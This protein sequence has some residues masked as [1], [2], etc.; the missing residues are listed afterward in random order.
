MKNTS[1]LE[2]PKPFLM[3]MME[4]VEDVTLPI[5]IAGGPTFSGMTNTPPKEHPDYDPD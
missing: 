3:V 1:G 5:A 4:E 2:S